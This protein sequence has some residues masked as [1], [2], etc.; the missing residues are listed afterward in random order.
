MIGPC[1]F[2]RACGCCP[3]HVGRELQPHMHMGK[4]RH[5][6]LMR[7]GPLIVVKIAV[8]T[9]GAALC[10]HRCMSLLCLRHLYFYSIDRSSG[11]KNYA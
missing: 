9:M 5:K 10:I 11:H 1:D 6:L 8:H 4:T 3:R 2:P 7:P